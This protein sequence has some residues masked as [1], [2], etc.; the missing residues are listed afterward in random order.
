MCLSIFQEEFNLHAIAPSSEGVLLDKELFGELY[1]SFENIAT[2][3]D[4]DRAGIRSARK[5]NE[6]YKLP[7]FFFGAVHRR[8]IFKVNE[9]GIKDFADYLSLNGIE[10]TRELIQTVYDGAGIID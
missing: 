9:G 4:F 6:T 1:N 7:F 5:Y 3:F 2:L 10:K 8:G